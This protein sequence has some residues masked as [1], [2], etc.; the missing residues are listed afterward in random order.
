MLFSGWLAVGWISNRAK[1]ELHR[2]QYSLCSD[3]ICQEAYSFLLWFY[4]AKIFNRKI[5]RDIV[6]CQFHW[7]VPGS[8]YPALVTHC[9]HNLNVYDSLALLAWYKMIPKNLAYI[10][11]TCRS[12]LFSRFSFVFITLPLWPWAVVWRIAA[13]HLQ[14]KNIVYFNCHFLIFK[15]CPV[16]FLYFPE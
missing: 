1:Q 10:F 7:C 6:A 8:L 5:I 15:P 16:R 14:K 13:L 9:G 4:K 3:F 12:T 11:L 2:Y